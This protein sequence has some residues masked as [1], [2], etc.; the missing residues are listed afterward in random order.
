MN[1]IPSDAVRSATRASSSSDTP[2]QREAGASGALTGRRVLPL[3]G[4]ACLVAV[5]YMDPGNWATALAAGSGFGYSLLCVVVLSSLMGMMLQAAAVRLGLVSGLDLAQACSRRLRPRPNLVLW[6]GCEIA[7]VACNVAEIL[8][9]A[10]GLNLLFHIPLT[11]AV[12]LTV[13]DVLL[14]LGLQSRGMQRLEIFVA[15]LVAVVAGTFALELTWLRPH[16]ADI[17]DGLIPG[18]GLF[19]NR[20]LLYLAVGIVGAT[21]MPHNLYLHSALVRTSQPLEG[22]ALRRAIR[23]ATH[24]SNAALGLAMLVNAGILVLAAG[25]APF[26][27]KTE[28]TLPDAY[29]LLSPALGVGAASTLFGIGLIAAGLSSSI[30]GTLAGQIVMEGFLNVRVS[31]ALR[32]VLTR[33]V[34]IIP[35]ALAASAFGAHGSGMALVLTQVILGLQ[36]PFAVLPLLWFTTRRSYLGAFAFGRCTSVLLWAIATLLVGLNIWMVARML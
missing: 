23:R 1:S 27:G 6:L 3:V 29:Q 28:W 36:L 8:G 25:A 15:F 14:I 17:L 34:A 7:I 35:A 19:T 18:P 4:P 20:E 2:P 10:C 5:G 24:D 22:T 33:A 26:G 31:R 12:A 32:S 16:P 30:T 11:L 9:M 21:V 13:L